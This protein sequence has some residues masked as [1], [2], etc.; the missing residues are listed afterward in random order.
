MAAYGADTVPIYAIAVSGIVSAFANTMPLD[1]VLAVTNAVDTT[2]PTP[3]TPVMLLT[4]RLLMM[5]SR[6]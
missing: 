2:A 4:V 6:T 1:T 5:L 3:A